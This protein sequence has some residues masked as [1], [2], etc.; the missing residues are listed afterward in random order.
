MQ[1][2]SLNARSLK[3]EAGLYPVFRM[4]IACDAEIGGTLTGELN[5]RYRVNGNLKVE[6]IDVKCSSS[7]DR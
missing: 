4:N 6:G 3:A 2:L 5:F 1:L 7:T